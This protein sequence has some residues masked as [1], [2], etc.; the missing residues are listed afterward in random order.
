MI[1]RIMSF[2]LYTVLQIFFYCYFLNRPNSVE[3][4]LIYTESGNEHERR[5][6]VHVRTYTVHIIYVRTL[7]LY[8]VHKFTYDERIS[9]HSLLC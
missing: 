6:D 8:Y 2:V 9:N 5:T 3:N 4:E 7:T 1:V